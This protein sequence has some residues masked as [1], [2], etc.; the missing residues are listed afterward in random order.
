MDAKRT[1]YDVLR[2][3]GKYDGSP[4]A[5]EDVIATLRAHGHSVKS[6]DAWCTE[7]IMA[8]LY[9]A[10]AIDMIGG[11]CQVSGDLK[12]QAQKKGIWHSGSKGIL[13]GDI[14]IFG[15]NGKT[16]HSELAIGNN[17]DLS[18]NYNGGCYRR[19]RSSHSSEILGYVC[20]KYA[21][22]K[23]DNLGVTLLSAE[24]MLGTFGSRK[25][26]EILL[27]SFG[28]EN[29]KAIQAEVDRV[30]DSTD[31]TIFDLAVYVI[32]GMAGNDSYRRK[33]IGAWYDAVQSKIGDIKALA[34][35]SAYGTA[36]DVLADKYGTGAVR[37][38]LLTFNGY[39]AQEVQDAVNAALERPVEPSGATF[40]SLFRDNPRATKEADGLQGNCFVFRQGGCALI[41]DAMLSGALAK[42]LAEIEGCTV[43]D[44]YLSHLHGDHT[45]NAPALIKSGRIRRLYIQDKSTVHKDYL[46]RYNAIVTA[47]K[48]AGTDV[49]ALKQGSVFDCGAIHGEI[50]F[51]QVDGS[52]ADSV[53]MRSL[54]ALFTMAG[55]T[56]LYCGDHHTGTK[57]SK[58]VFSRH[59]DVLISSHH[60]LYTG[61]KEAF[62]KA[63]SPDWII[64]A[65]WKSWPVG[66]VCQD[67]KTRAAQVVYQKYGN[68]L[69]GDVCGRTQMDV[70][71]DHTITVKAEKGMK[72]HT[73]TY[74]KDGKVFRK[75]VHTCD[76]CTFHAVRS[77]V[78]EGGT[79]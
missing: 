71:T 21:E 60:Q 52:T 12:K 13:P 15:R 73:V 25:T 45:G 53:N 44:L 27:A 41:V 46:S 61:D 59:V 35:K 34:G 70:G 16:N 40:V 47:C 74:K 68:L 3:A 17:I 36:G 14:V 4:T 79:L 8:I 23:L 20:P 55:R 29:A 56:W 22:K 6:S 57:E 30:W 28:A 26:R 9:D 11:Y 64:G 37:K 32:A 77:M 5:H 49:V 19:T 2:A 50:I 24:T 54:C 18:G 69:P 63:V 78:P 51:Q 38:L 58:L 67:A 62:V 66:T 72:G 42:I 39:D 65:G 75:T 31:K 43:A 76:S 33:R 10:G 1:R 48:K 7:T